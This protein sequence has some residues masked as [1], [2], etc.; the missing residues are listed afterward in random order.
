M[1]IYI[2]IPMSVE[3]QI[4]SIGDYI[5]YKNHNYNIYKGCII[6]KRN[7]NNKEYF[8]IIKQ[9]GGE[10]WT[11]VLPINKIDEDDFLSNFYLNAVAKKQ[12]L[13]YKNMISKKFYEVIN[14]SINDERINMSK[15]VFMYSLKQTLNKEN[16]ISPETWCIY[17]YVNRVFREH[18]PYLI[19]ETINY[20]YGSTPLIKNFLKKHKNFMIKMQGTVDSQLMLYLIDEKFL[21]FKHSLKIISDKQFVNSSFHTRI[22]KLEK[23]LFLKESKVD[24]NKKIRLKMKVSKKIYSVELFLNELIDTRFIFN[25][26][27]KYKYKYNGNKYFKCSKKIFVNLKSNENFENVTEEKYIRKD[28]TKLVK[29][30]NKVEVKNNTLKIQDINNKV[31]YEKYFDYLYFRTFIK[32]NEYIYII[33]DRELININTLKKT[34]LKYIEDNNLDNE[35]Y[36]NKQENMLIITKTFS[37]G[38]I[39]ET[40]ISVK[41]YSLKDEKFLGTFELN[42]NNDISIIYDIDISEII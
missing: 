11:G 15:K 26:N 6:S 39:L 17:W 18:E 2:Y 40:I 13:N 36:F 24:E 34:Y 20:C 27:E 29:S 28:N 1:Y 25:N 38:N 42:Y 23:I 21:E 30:V 7:Y 14:N 41:L 9:L 5:E 33:N 8:D 32:G 31:L 37:E 35:T 4:Y 3:T 22:K 19:N 10:I 16:K 12:I